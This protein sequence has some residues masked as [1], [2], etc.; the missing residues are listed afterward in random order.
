MIRSRPYITNWIP[1]ISPRSIL[2][3]TPKN[4]T[5]NSHTHT[6]N[7]LYFNISYKYPFWLT[8][9]STY[10]YRDR[11]K[12]PNEIPTD[13][14]KPNKKGVFPCIL[15][16]KILSLYHLTRTNKCT[17]VWITILW[18]FITQTTPKQVF[19]TKSIESDIH[20][21]CIQYSL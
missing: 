10:H 2:P 12:I 8:N 19:I 15:H 4:M 17:N 9:I 18:F 1:R 14:K 11:N 3:L 21:P 6:Q 7:C 5:S 20:T 16:I 13:T